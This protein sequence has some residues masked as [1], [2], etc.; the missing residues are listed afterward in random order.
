MYKKLLVCGITLLFVFTLSSGV[1]AQMSSLYGL[2]SM[3]MSD[4]QLDYIRPI[5]PDELE[6]GEFRLSPIISRVNN[7]YERND[8][9]DDYS[10][11]ADNS[12][13]AYMLIF[14]S[15]FTEKLSLHS[16]F[17]YQPWEDYSYNNPFSSYSYERRSTLTDLFLNYEMK[18][19]RIL[20][21]GYNRTLN[22]EKE[23]DNDNILE[24]ED[25]DTTNIYYLGFEI[26]GSFAGNNE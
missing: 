1:F 3:M 20:F 5:D 9:D 22:K 6:K 19:D 21:F 15:K 16:K 4:W 11:D 10:Y 17:I 18:E 8:L 13:M 26:R 12:S 2:D 23:Y 25:E 7:A 24:D 14:D